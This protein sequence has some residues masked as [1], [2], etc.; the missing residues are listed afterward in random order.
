MNNALSR[1]CYAPCRWR[2]L[3]ASHSASY[4]QSVPEPGEGANESIPYLGSARRIGIAT[5]QSS[6][7]CLTITRTT[8][9]MF[10]SLAAVSGSTLADL[11]LQ[12]FEKWPTMV[13]QPIQANHRGLEQLWIVP[14]LADPGMRC[15]CLAEIDEPMEHHAGARR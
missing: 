9:L 12:L 8:E 13:C 11:G 4:C 15:C 14:A 3:A 5:S 10:S 7:R 6:K 1:L 2:R